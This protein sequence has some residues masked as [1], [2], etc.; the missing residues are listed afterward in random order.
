M[1][2]GTAQYYSNDYRLAVFGGMKLILLFS[3]YNLAGHN[4]V[5]YIFLTILIKR[6]SDAQ[7]STIVMCI[8]YLTRPNIIYRIEWM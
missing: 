6:L 4:R 7:K 5:I 3:T 8:V 2:I 1:C